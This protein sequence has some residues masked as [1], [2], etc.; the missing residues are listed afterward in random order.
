M[1]IVQLLFW[2][3]WNSELFNKYNNETQCNVVYLVTSKSVC[4]ITAKYFDPLEIHFMVFQK[5]Y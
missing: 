5:V 1:N 2:K 4:T 3:Q